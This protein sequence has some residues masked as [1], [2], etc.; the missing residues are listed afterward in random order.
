[1]GGLFHT[2]DGAESF[3]SITDAIEPSYFREALVHDMGHPFG[4]PMNSE[5]WM[6]IEMISS[7]QQTRERFP[8]AKIGVY[9]GNR[10]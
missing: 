8:N 3:R 4:W 9:S 2:V 5:T 7:I 1:M 6:P 10:N